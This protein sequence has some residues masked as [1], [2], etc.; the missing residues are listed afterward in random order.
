LI[1]GPGLAENRWIFV[2]FFVLPSWKGSSSGTNQSTSI[3]SY[4]EVRR[5]RQQTI[6]LL[7]NW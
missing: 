7:E 2:E 1:S 6:Y 4:K 3:Y 5:I